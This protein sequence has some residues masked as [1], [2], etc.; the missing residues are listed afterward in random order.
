MAVAAVFGVV[1]ALMEMNERW[2]ELAPSPTGLGLGMLL[3]FVAL[4]TILAGAMLGALWHAI[5]PRSASVYLVPLASGFIAGEA[6][7]A[8]LVPVLLYFGFGSG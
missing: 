4:S 1:F 5:A 7:I 6:L 8:V 3:P 2:K